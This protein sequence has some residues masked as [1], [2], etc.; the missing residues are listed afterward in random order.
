MKYWIGY[1]VAL[2]FAACTWALKSFAATHS[3]LVDILYPYVSRMWVAFLSRRTA[4]TGL[5]IWQILVVAAALGI[6]AAVI[7]YIWRKKNPV[8]WIGWTLAVI[9]ALSLVNT[10][11]FGLNRYSGALA[12]DIRL[13][14]ADYVPTDLQNALVYYQ[15]HANSLAKELPRDSKGDVIL[16]FDFVAENAGKGFKVL[17]QNKYYSVFAGNTVPVKK[18]GWSWI[19]NITGNT[20]QF[21][22]LTG[23]AVVNENIPTQGLPFAVC[24][25]M[26]QRICI[27]NNP[28]SA[29]AA[30]LA[31][32]NN[33]NPA[34]KYSGYFM[35]YRYCYEALAAIP[36][37]ATSFRAKENEQLKHDVDAYNKSFAKRDD[38]ASGK[39]PQAA[40]GMKTIHA[41]D[42]LVSWHLQ[43]VVEPMHKQEDSK[44][45]P[46]DETKVDLSGLANAGGK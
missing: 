4:F 10:G 46:M 18:L 8:R 3:L 44:F 42:L 7:F 22:P 28:D 20:T 36:G 31:C 21:F 37:G 27:S 16:D 23:E 9:C 38:R 32:I 45:D 2:I 33:P 34:I 1:L 12:D 19:Y 11:F 41:A 39:V 29:L 30:I 5:C 13:K 35:A 24:R 26:A 14:T 25:V 17:S 43:T 6:I 40:G 15:K